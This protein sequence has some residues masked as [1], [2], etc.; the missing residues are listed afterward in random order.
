LKPNQRS[1]AAPP[2][3]F[4]IYFIQPYDPPNFKDERKPDE[5]FFHLTGADDAFQQALQKYAAALDLAGTASGASKSTY[6]SRASQFLQVLVKWLHERLAS[7]YKVTYQG[8]TKPLTEWS[9][10]SASGVVWRWRRTLGIPR[11]G[12]EG[13]RRLIQAASSR[14]GEASRERGVSDKECDERSRKARQ[15]NLQQ[16]LPKGYHGPRWTTEQLQLLGT[17]PDASPLMTAESTRGSPRPTV[18][19]RFLSR[20]LHER[21]VTPSLTRTGLS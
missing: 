21:K 17:L 6:L 12:T 15:L 13:S 10:G 5:V 1:T 3:D 11:N 9:K 19:L 2:R 20:P 14:G 8:K 7:A 4:Y 18:R 16:Y